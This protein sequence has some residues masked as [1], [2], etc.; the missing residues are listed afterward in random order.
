MTREGRLVAVDGRDAL[1]YVL[2]RPGND[3]A[4][5]SVEAGANG[6]PKASAAVILR[7]IADQWDAE[8]NG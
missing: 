1:V 8:D 7:Q 6:L 3:D 4:H 2:V 5:V